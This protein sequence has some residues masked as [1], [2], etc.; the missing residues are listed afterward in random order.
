MTARELAELVAEMR[1]AQKEYFRTK[2]PA[3]IERSKQL[4]RKVDAACRQVLEQPT[5]FGDPD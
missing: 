3:A 1:S 2:N 5:L 4:E